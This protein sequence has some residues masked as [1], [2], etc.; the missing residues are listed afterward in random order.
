MKETR[1]RTLVKR[2]TLK[3]FLKWAGGKRQLLPKIKAYYPFRNK[4]ITKYAEPFVGGGAVL[5]DVLNQYDLEQV[6]ISDVNAELINA[7]RSIQ[8]H[9]EDLLETLWHWQEEFIPRSKDERKMYYLQKRAR[10]NELKSNGDTSSSIE[11]AALMIFL[12][13]TCFNG[14]FRVNRKGL[15][16]VP[17]GAYKTPRICDRENIQEIS[18]KLRGITIVCGDYK[19]SINFV[20]SHTFVYLDPPYRPISETANFTAYTEVL[21]DDKKQLEFA[22]FVRALNQ[23]GARIVMSN[24]DPKNTNA[25]DDFFDTLYGAYQIKRV[26]AARFIN[27][28]GGARGHVKELLI[29]NF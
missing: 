28:K 14:L 22:A 1:L 20:D 11:R 19:E 6:Y 27:A 18:E 5:F 2:K 24:S 17:M 10:F 26:E 7:Y 3:P 15:F 13:K 12:N 25:N 9:A 8:Q 21:F 23:K 4:E 29:S 16:N